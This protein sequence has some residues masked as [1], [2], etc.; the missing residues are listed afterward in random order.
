MAKHDVVEEVVDGCLMSRARQLA[1]VVTSIYEDELR[2]FEIKPSQ[3][4]L[5]VAVA[6][7]GPVRRIELGRTT[8]LDPSTLTRNLAVMMANGWIKEV[9]EGDDG[10]GNPLCIAPKGRDLIERVVPRW[11]SAQQ[12]TRKLLGDDRANAL[13]RMLDSA[14]TKG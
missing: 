5:L 2:E 1:R 10:R 9:V 13:L 8:D 14:K 6:K 7:A 12:R 11:R 3:F 4:N